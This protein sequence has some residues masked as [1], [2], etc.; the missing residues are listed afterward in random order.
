M[1][2]GNE[3]LKQAVQLYQAGERRQAARTLAL[4]LRQDL[5]N[6]QAWWW[7]AACVDSVEQKLD[8]YQRI[9]QINPLHTGAR[10]ALLNMQA[11][12]PP[13]GPETA[14]ETASAVTNRLHGPGALPRRPLLTP[15]QTDPE[16]EDL[17]ARAAQAEAAEDFQAAYDLYARAAA[18][19]SSC[20]L[21]WLGKGYTAGRLSTPDHNG[22]PEFFECLTRAVLSQDRFGLT[23]PQALSQLDPALAQV[24]DGRLQNLMAAVARLAETGSLSTKNV[25]IIEQVRLADC[26]FAVRQR[27]NPQ[28]ALAGEYAALAELSLSAFGQITAGVRSSTRGALA[29]RE[30]TQTFRNLL[31]N[32]LAASG[33]NR[34]PNFL[35]QVDSLAETV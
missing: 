8:C 35:H 4:L 5:T 27:L 22:I 10:T 13:P 30:L 3:L 7:L 6:E 14:A 11:N 33:L 26:A 19:D 12:L 24:L 25:F 20:A 32:N 21:A 1:S 34:D 16:A 23:L 29:R 17:M 28:T 18:I 9:L 2:T 15:H 31:L